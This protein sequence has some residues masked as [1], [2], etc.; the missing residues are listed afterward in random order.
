MNAP[1]FYVIAIKELRDAVRT[2]WFLLYAGAFLV[3]AG[4]LAYLTTAFAGF[5]G[6][7]GFGRAAA[8]LVNLV[9]L[10][11]PLMGLTAGALT[12]TS[13]RERNTWGYLLAHPLSRLEV[14]GGKFVGLGMALVIAIFTG[15]GIT[16]LVLALQ[17]SGLGGLNFAAFVGLTVLLGLVA[18][19][20]GLLISTLT[21][22]VAAALGAAVFI[23]L[24]LVFLGDLGLMATAMVTQLGIQ[25]VFIL[26]LL[27][28]LQIYKV[29]AITLFQPT[30]EV[31]GPVGLYASDTLGP[32]LQTLFVGL[33]TVWVL[34]PLALAYLAL[35]G[36]E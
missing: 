5:S 12:I 33:L 17:G 36:R 2:R 34:L 29:A 18:V 28:P 25:N 15:F 26:S 1:A 3:L 35:L 23:W 7:H 14:L 31:L 16:G 9:L 27:N 20:M 6:L 30:L 8:G 11:V 13:E 22:R 4:G 19:A 21:H 32:W 24:V 10:V